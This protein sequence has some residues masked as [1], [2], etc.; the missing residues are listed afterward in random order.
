MKLGKRAGKNGNS[1]SLQTAQYHSSS[2]KIEY[3]GL[4]SIGVFH[5]INGKKSVLVFSAG[6]SVVF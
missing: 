4:L 1:V 3:C 6:T 5:L 2:I